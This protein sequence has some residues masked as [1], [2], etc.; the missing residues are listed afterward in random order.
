MKKNLFRRILPVLAVLCLAVL[1]MCVTAQAKTYKNEWYMSKNGRA[2]YYDANGQMV[3]NKI[4]QIGTKCYY[5]DSKGMQH[6]GWIKSGGYYYYF[7]IGAKEK[8]Y[9]RRNQTVNGIKLD[10]KGRA[11]TNKEKAR[12]LAKAN[13][14]VFSVTN[15][16]MTQTQKN[17]AC[18]LYVRNKTRWRNIGSFRRSNK[19]WDQFYAAYLLDRGYGD[20]Y[21]G[22]CG[23]AYLAVAAGAKKV[24][25]TSS[26]GHGWAEIN[27][28]FYD[29]N[30]SK[31]TGSVD[32]YFAVPA[33][34]S[35]RSGRPAWARN[36]AYVK[37]VDA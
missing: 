8:G 33:S 29:P 23:F 7:N 11:V 2:Y 32:K 9:R 6:V 27:G 26:G 37:R 36:R 28:K 4:K 20:C 17:K 21:V 35:G 15:F 30:W 1:G 18:F 10:V 25:A 16:N 5:F 3:K 24:N 13:T 22:G 19:N 31:V 34:L 12:L 14:I